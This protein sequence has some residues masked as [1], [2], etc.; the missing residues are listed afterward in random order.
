[1]HPLRAKAN[2]GGLHSFICLLPVV[3][4]YFWGGVINASVSVSVFLNGRSTPVDVV[5]ATKFLLCSLRKL[6]IN[7]RQNIKMLITAPVCF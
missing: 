1:M 7:M 2:C 4:L 3:P 6:T 5:K